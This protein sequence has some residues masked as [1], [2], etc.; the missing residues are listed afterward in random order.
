[1]RAAGCSSPNL[2][3]TRRYASIAGRAVQAAG[4]RLT[5]RKGWNV[6]HRKVVAL[7][8][9]IVGV[10][11][12]GPAWAGWP[13]DKPIEVVIGFAPG[14]GTDVMARKLLPFVE[15]RLGGKPKFVVLNK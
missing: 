8:A 1:M 11:A 7:V 15:Q 9:A 10:A 12:C 6:M 13:D 2:A 3:V 4:S 5:T 14:G